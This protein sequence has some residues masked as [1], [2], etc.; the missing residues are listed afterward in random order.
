MLTKEILLANQG[1]LHARPATFFVQ[2]CSTLKSDINISLYGK[3]ANAKSIVN[4]MLL[5]AGQGKTITLSVE[6]EDEALA[7]EKIVDFFTNLTL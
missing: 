1:G 2:L 6:G 7:M 4:I 3:Q 5:G